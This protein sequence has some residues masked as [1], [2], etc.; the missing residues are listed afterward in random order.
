MAP[1]SCCLVN[2]LRHYEQQRVCVTR[3]PLLFLCFGAQPAPSHRRVRRSRP[4]CLLAARPS[5]Q[6]LCFSLSP[7]HRRRGQYEHPGANKVASF[8]Y[9]VSLGREGSSRRLS[10]NLNP[11]E[12]YI[13]GPPGSLLA[14][15]LRTHT[16]HPQT[17]WA[18]WHQIDCLS[19]EGSPQVGQNAQQA[20]S[21]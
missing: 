7:A 17:P 16:K 12:S 3:S 4:F 20:A 9:L 18:A 10:S 13:S 14:P 1:P 19:D 21:N 6:Y 15:K 2:S 5:E 8:P 11:V